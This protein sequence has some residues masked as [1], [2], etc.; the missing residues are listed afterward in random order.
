MSFLFF[1]ILKL[2]TEAAK[3]KRESDHVLVLAASESS[4]AYQ[5]VSI[6]TPMRVK[7]T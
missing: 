6:S 2:K 3:P 5:V 4:I 7:P 1:K